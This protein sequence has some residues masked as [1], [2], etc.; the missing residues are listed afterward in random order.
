M[1]HSEER[2]LKDNTYAQLRDLILTNELRAG[3]KL[4]DRD[5]AEKL[6]VSRTPVREAL[7][8]L[9]MMGLVEARSRRGYYVC[10]YTPKQMSDLYELREFLE[11]PAARLAAENA[12]E[13]HFS[14]MDLILKD[15][16]KLAA[17]TFS[18]AKAVEIDLRI[19]DLIAR[20]SGNESL[21]QTV[22]NLMDKVVCFIWVDWADTA[23]VDSDS[24]T[25]AYLEHE[26]LLLSIKE[27]NGERAAQI[28]KKHISNARK[29][30]ERMLKDRTE[31][32]EAF[33]SGS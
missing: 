33:R 18:R 30:L 31:L 15:S 28:M 29:A 1:A 6:G 9:A 16:K 24:M 19:H 21:Q 17:N 5:L 7:G 23:R 14:E 8:R 4:P 3:Q 32:R 13:A 27:R 11:V 26:E 2:P 22:Q 10:Q 20:A 12:T 25:A